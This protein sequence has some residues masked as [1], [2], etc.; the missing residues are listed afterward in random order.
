MTPPLLI[1]TAIKPE[2]EKIDWPESEKIDWPES[3]KIDWPES[4]KID[5]QEEITLKKYDEN[6]LAQIIDQVDL[7]TLIKTQKLSL[8][9]IHKYIVS[10]T[11]SK[12]A[13]SEENG[14]SASY[15]AFHQNYTEDEI[16]GQ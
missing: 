5:W 15:I 4:E 11:T 10:K 7:R 8:D 16:I 12:Y 14:I 13:C 3:E 2:S 1:I 9:F 6:T